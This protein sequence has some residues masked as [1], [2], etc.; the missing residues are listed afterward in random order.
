VPPTLRSFS[1]YALSRGKGVPREARDALAKVREAVEADRGRGVR[2]SVQSTRLG[3]EGETRLCATYADPRD[4]ARAY[5]RT[6]ALVK[7][8]DLVN[9][10][11][12]PCESGGP[13][14]STQRQEEKP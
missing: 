12:E 2:V 7:G 5:E 9:L 11:A 1:V 10:V 3:L 13:E 14:P 8:V 6:Q 4:A